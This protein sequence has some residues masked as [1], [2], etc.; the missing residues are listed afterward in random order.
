MSLKK[1][2]DLSKKGAVVYMG[3][4][5]D[6]QTGRQTDRCTHTHTHTQTHTHTHGTDNSFSMLVYISLGLR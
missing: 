3:K 2:R 6:R 4:L 1:Y 5:Q